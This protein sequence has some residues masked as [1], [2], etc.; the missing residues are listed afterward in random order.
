MT[1]AQA[2][3]FERVYEHYGTDRFPADAN[4][5]VSTNATAWL[6]VLREHAKKTKHVSVGTDGVQYLYE[7]ANIDRTMRLYQK[8]EYWLKKYG[9]V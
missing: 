6:V 4:R 1:N 3:A 7:W 2:K 8:S 9:L 5:F